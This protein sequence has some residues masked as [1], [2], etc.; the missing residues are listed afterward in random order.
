MLDKLSLG[1]GT[2]RPKTALFRRISVGIP[3]AELL[4]VAL[5]EDCPVPVRT[6]LNATK[7]KLKFALVSLLA[8]A[9]ACSTA[10]SQTN[11]ASGDT[12]QP[13]TAPPANT[14]VTNAT[15]TPAAVSTNAPASTNTPA[16]D[17]TAPK[18]ASND[19]VPAPVVVAQVATPAPAPAAVPAPAPTATADSTAHDPAAIIPLIVMDE[20]PLTDAIKNLARQAGLNYMLD[21]KI[22]YNAPDSGGNVRAQPTVSLRWENLTADQALNAVLANYNLIL[23]DDPKTHIARIS[24]KDPAA[25]DPLVTK[26]VQLKFCDATNM[27][28]NVET[29][30]QDK[31]SK[32]LAD[33]RTS[34]LVIVATEVELAAADQLIA[35]LDQPTKEVLIEAKLVELQKNPSTTK[36]V[37]WSATLQAQHMTFGNNVLGGA[38][39]HPYGGTY[40]STVIQGLIGAGTNTQ[41]VPVG[42][43]NQVTYTANNTVQ[44]PGILANTSHGLDP[45][46]MFLN[47]DGV[48][49]VLSFLNTEADAKVLS[50]PRAVTLDNQ[51]ATLSV[52]TAQPIFKTTAGTQGSPGGS[53]VTYT[54]LGTILHVTPRISANNFINLRVVPEVSDLGGTITKTVSGLISQADF[55]DVRKIDTRVLI[56]SGNT[57]VMGGLVSDQSTKG[58]TKVP[59]LG[60]IPVLG[61]AFRSESK[62][63]NKR[64]LIIFVTPTIVQNEDFQPSET[65]F[66]KTRAP[67]S[68]GSDFSAWDSGN[69]QDWSKL[70]HSKKSQTND[71]S[72]SDFPTT[73]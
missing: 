59:L 56:P 65:A 67:E 2:K 64:N 70:M 3:P 23:V 54:N 27:V 17:A 19:P 51:E 45:A 41:T 1:V 68:K 52:T 40:S 12:N 22:N 39:T 20:V 48:S 5:G 66:L 13:P 35:R 62:T 11:A 50:T 61:Y 36:G 24:I 15:E 57:L 26:I 32:V 21:P 53:E 63:Q 44:N 47:A 4:P 72:Y 9:L 71:D 58:N 43:I 46:T 7:M 16:A 25:P 34:Q 18:V 14:A 30:L 31:R 42:V 37:D 33:T 49:A 60:D 69:P 6:N 38:S 73:K 55:F 10:R 29:V 8:L 28:S